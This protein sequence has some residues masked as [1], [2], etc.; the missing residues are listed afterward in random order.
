M[1]TSL[2]RGVE[3]VYDF[4]KTA[5]QKVAKE[6]WS[7]PVHYGEIPRDLLDY[8][9]NKNKPRYIISHIY[10]SYIVYLPPS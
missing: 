5:G 1:L 7:F 4:S 10:K 6:N 8:S 2:V 9:E 3:K